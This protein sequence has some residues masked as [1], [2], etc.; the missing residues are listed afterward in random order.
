ML[1]WALSTNLIDPVKAGVIKARMILVFTIL[2]I[3]FINHIYRLKLNQKWLKS[4]T[5]PEPIEWAL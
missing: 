5:Q 2:F 4:F 3:L 1:K